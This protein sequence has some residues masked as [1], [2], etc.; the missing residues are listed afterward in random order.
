MVIL[1]ISFKMQLDALNCQLQLVLYALW[2]Q[3][4]T[5]NVVFE[6]LV[7]NFCSQIIHPLNTHDCEQ[8]NHP[9]TLT[10]ICASSYLVETS[11]TNCAQGNLVG[12]H[13]HCHH[14]SSVHSCFS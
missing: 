6:F 14:Y 12:T 11:W 8:D 1:G 3:P 5:A 2:T 4:D 13:H 7:G 10:L 9:I